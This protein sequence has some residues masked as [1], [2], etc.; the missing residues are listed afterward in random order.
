MTMRFL[1]VGVATLG[2]SGLLALPASADGAGEVRLTIPV[3][4]AVDHLLVT[5]PLGTVAGT[6]STVVVTAQDRVGQTAPG[7][8]GTVH[9]SSS[10]RQAGLPADF[11]FS[12]GALLLRWLGL[13]IQVERRRG[14]AGHAGP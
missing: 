6:V 14:G 2:L 9:F 4:P 11:T 12:G 5:S 7:Y 3:T 10:D 8:R 1:K 13:R